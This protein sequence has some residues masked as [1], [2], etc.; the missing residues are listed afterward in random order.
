MIGPN[1]CTRDWR[2]ARCAPATEPLVFRQQPVR[3]TI[4]GEPEFRWLE[5]VTGAMAVLSADRDVKPDFQVFLER[6]GD[7]MRGHG[8]NGPVEIEQLTVRI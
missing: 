3:T 8:V 4:D 6:I 1:D 5:P 2:F 7:F